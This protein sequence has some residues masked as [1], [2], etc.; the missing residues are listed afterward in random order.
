MA[1]MHKRVKISII[2]LR[3]WEIKE[4]SESNIILQD[5]YNGHL[6]H[7]QY[8]SLSGLRKKFFHS[9]LLTMRRHAC[10]VDGRLL[11][12]SAPS[13]QELHQVTASW[14]CESGCCRFCHF[15]GG[16]LQQPARWSAGVPPGRT[17]VGAQCRR[18]ARL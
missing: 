14:G 5:C 2:S 11:L 15:S 16:P 4:L 6:A 8:T 10:C 17:P 18:K 12:S 3:L 7:F 1:Q 9:T 13:H